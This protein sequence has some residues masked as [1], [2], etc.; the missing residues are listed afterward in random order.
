MHMHA[1]LEALYPGDDG[2]HAEQRVR[3][4]G[5]VGGAPEGDELAEELAPLELI[6]LPVGPHHFLRDRHSNAVQ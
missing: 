6:S 1:K 5:E 2:V 3:E 4:A